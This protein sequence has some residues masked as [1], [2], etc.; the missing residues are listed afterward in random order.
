M[1]VKINR[2]IREYTESM[3]FGLSLRQFI[4]CV[5]ALAS[6]VATHFA[7][8]A[9]IGLEA[10]SLVCMLAAVPFAVIGYVKYI[11]TVS[12]YDNWKIFLRK[13]GFDEMMSG[14]FYIVEITASR[15]NAA[16]G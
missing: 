6:S 10:V 11:R 9:L 1:E 16:D 8:K 15:F 13:Y 4:C 2:E 14:A 12:V 7:L 5:L 3:F